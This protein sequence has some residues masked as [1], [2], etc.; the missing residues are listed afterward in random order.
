RVTAGDE[1]LLL[2][3]LQ[4]Y[5]TL[6]GAMAMTITIPL[7][8]ALS[9]RIGR[10]PVYLAGGTFL[11]LIALPAFW[12]IDTRS[13]LLIDLALVLAMGGIGL[14]YGP[15][16][17]I[18]SELFDTTIRYSGASLSYQIASMLAGGLTPFIA[19]ALLARFNGASWPIALYLIGL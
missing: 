17:A 16:A 6:L 18:F 8:A 1:D 19:T 10:L 5:G 15:Q 11:G 3:P 2:W 7:A 13:P 4:L 9:D 14:M 12:L